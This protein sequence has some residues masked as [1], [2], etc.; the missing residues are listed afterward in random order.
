MAVKD[1]SDIWVMTEGSLVNGLTS[2]TLTLAAD[3]IDITTQ[4]SNKYKEFLAGEKSGV[5]SF[6]TLDDEADANGYDELFDAWDAGTAVA[7]I[8]GSGIKTAG[9]RII[10]A[11]GI[12]TALDKNDAKNATSAVSCTIR[13]TGTISR[14]TSV[15]TV[16]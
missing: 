3:E 7:V 14:A 4:D 12:I 2:K 9:E 16:A 5:V 10:S 6:E 13:L 1:G 11:S 8:Y 15:T